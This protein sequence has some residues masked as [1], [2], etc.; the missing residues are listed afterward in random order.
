MHALWDGGGVN[1]VTMATSTG[2]VTVQI[3][4]FHAWSRVTS[5]K[6]E[7]NNEKR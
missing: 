4:H 6:K 5:A 3:S 1:Q 2:Q 7:M